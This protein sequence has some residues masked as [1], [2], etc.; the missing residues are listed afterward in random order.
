[1]GC[2]EAGLGSAGRAGLRVAQ[3]L[4]S[5]ACCSSKTIAGLMH[6]PDDVRDTAHTDC[7]LPEPEP[8]GLQGSSAIQKGIPLS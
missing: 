2:S 1:M 8:P 7:R 5:S 6:T 4:Q 3:I